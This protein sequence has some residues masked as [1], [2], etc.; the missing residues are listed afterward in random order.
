MS[1]CDLCGLPATTAFGLHHANDVV[2]MCAE[3]AQQ[4]H[5]ARAELQAAT[6]RQRAQIT[7]AT[8][9]AIPA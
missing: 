7:T 6:R 5:D 3:H 4:E 8:R 9:E 2:H 1:W